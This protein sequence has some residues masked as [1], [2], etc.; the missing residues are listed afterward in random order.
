MIEKTQSYKT[1]DGAVHPTIQMAA[2]GGKQAQPPAPKEWGTQIVVADRGFV[3]VGTVKTDGDFATIT[4]ARNIR[5]WGT[6]QGLG[7][8]IDGPKPETKLDMVGEVV[9]PMR[10]VI[11]FIKCSRNW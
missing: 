5:K 6:T 4:N 2:I 1:S 9:L 10:A 8:L 11:S 3:Y 7:E